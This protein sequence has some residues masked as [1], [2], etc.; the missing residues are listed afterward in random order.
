MR[1]RR[2]YGKFWK[3]LVWLVLWTS[4]SIYGTNTKQLAAFGQEV[5]LDKANRLL[6]NLFGIEYSVSLISHDLKEP[7]NDW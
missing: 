6:T 4:E 2:T 5:T 3:S 1:L 7:T